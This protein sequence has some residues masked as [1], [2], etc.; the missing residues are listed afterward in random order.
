MKKTLIFLFV[1]LLITGCSRVVIDAP[2]D[3]SVYL[4]N[5]KANYPLVTDYHVRYAFSLIPTV[6]YEGM[7]QNAQ[8]LAPDM[9]HTY[10]IIG[11][12]EVKKCYIKVS[13]SFHDWV[14]DIVSGAIPIVGQLHFLYSGAKTIEIY[15]K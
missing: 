7:L 5:S 11:Q 13:Y 4:T 8:V 12:H 10:G 3:K 14:V 1:I 15:G 6:S 9:N 2:Q